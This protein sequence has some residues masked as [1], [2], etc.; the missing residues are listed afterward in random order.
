MKIA[1]AQRSPVLLDRDR[2]LDV[3]LDSMREAAAGG[4]SLVAFGETFL[5]GYTI[6]LDR[7]DAAQ[8]DSDRQKDI[9]ARYLANAIN[10]SDGD[11]NP[12]LA[13]ARELN[14]AVVLGIAE[15]DRTRGESLFA[16]A[17]SVSQTG[18]VV[19]SHRKLVPTYEERL[20]WASGDAQ[21]LRTWPLGEFTVGVLN[22]WENW[23]PLPRAT[24][25]AQGENLH[26]AIW[27]G[28]QRLTADVT[29]F[30]A[31]ESRSFVVSASGFYTGKSVPADFP[32]RDAVVRDDDEL[33]QDGGSCIAAPDG[34]WVLEPQVGRESI[35]FA[36][37]DRNAVRRERQNF[38]PA[39]HYS[40]PELLQ[41]RVDRRRSALSTD[42]DHV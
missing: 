41:L 40:R 38:D 24:L 11:L 32:H 26:V 7:T 34:T 10:I 19:A 30:I 35:L 18:E 25:Y 8:F 31:R 12:V 15:T 37:L 20:A 27:P 36:E 29:R 4:A 42:D 6:W 3:V 39:G 33:I 22:C 1:I 14:L 17:V 28:S 16:T 13:T 9:H 23:M 2:T 21:G 5:P